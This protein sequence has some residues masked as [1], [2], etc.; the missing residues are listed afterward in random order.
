MI[1]SGQKQIIQ[2]FV[3]QVIELFRIETFQSVLTFL[4][5]IPGPIT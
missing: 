4:P 1:C 5:P 3:G 2:N